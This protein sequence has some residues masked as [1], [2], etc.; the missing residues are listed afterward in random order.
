VRET[1]RLLSGDG[2]EV[3]RVV[4]GR[5]VLLG[6]V[7]VE[8]G[9]R[10]RRVVR[11]GERTGGGSGVVGG[12]PDG[13]GCRLVGGR[14]EGPALDSTSFRS[15]S[16][17]TESL[18]DFLL[19]LLL[20]ET[21]RS[22]PLQSSTLPPSSSFVDFYLLRL[23]LVVILSLFS[24]LILVPL[25]V[26]NVLP[27]FQSLL[28]DGDH[29]VSNS[30]LTSL[31]DVSLDSVELF[32]DVGGESLLLFGIEEVVDEG[33]HE[34]W[35]GRSELLLSGCPSLQISMNVTE[36][37]GE[38][39]RVVSRRDKGFRKRRGRRRNERRGEGRSER[40]KANDQTQ[41]SRDRQFELTDLRRM[42][43]NL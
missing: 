26:R 9:E 39:V 32:D 34:L 11:V 30:L 18:V 42:F 19:L 31:V 24:I 4:V 37:T 21:P 3:G 15:S 16:S 20:V 33:D 10:S 6:G 17:E 36:N 25:V 8:R 22:L 29:V 38:S 43:V 7:F 35:I 28:D 1:L 40:A 14:R 23:L 5:D 41:A 27:S 12:F 13:I 2:V